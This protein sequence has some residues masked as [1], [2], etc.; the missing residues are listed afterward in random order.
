M[1][2]DLEAR[3]RRARYRAEHRGTKEMDL[4]LG[5]FAATRVAAM[6]EAELALFERLLAVPD[7]ELNAWILDPGQIAASEFR[8]LIR[9]LRQ[10][11]GLEA[12]NP[13]AP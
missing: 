13:V 7:P 12:A 5:G 2:I 3:R 8:D 11:Y 1:P 9:A 4:M 6:C 10:L